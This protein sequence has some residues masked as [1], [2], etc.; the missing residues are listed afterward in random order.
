MIATS[1]FE[2]IRNFAKSQNCP[3]IMTSGGD[4][5]STSDRYKPVP[6][7][8]VI[9]H[10][11]D[12]GYS[13]TSATSFQRDLG[14]KYGSYAVILDAPEHMEQDGLRPQL[15]ITNSANG[16]KKLEITPGFKVYVCSNSMVFA[17]KKERKISFKHIGDTDVSKVVT[18]A[19]A[20][21]E[22][23]YGNMFEKVKVMKG[24]QLSQDK[25]EKLAQQIFQV[26][27][28]DKSK[29]KVNRFDMSVAVGNALKPLYEGHSDNSMWSVVNTI[30]SH[31]IE[32][33]DGKTSDRLILGVNKN[34]K[35][36]RQ[37]R[38]TAKIKHKKNLLVMEVAQ[39]F[40][41]ELSE[42]FAQLV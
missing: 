8:Q 34:G 20:Y 6:M 7:F 28:M 26:L 21:M 1:K 36:K 27:G 38:A 39:Q 11:M 33:S 18:E 14:C 22:Q 17:Q 24:I 31:I 19:L 10:M 9:N 37:R 25:K 16:T 42:E 12:H 15:C 30:Q 41:A 2:Q 40:S 5:E 32:N 4:P 13:L 29:A 35:A 3:Q 23:L